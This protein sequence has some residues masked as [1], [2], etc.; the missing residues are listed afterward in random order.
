MASDYADMEEVYSAME[1]LGAKKIRDIQSTDSYAF[2]VK[3]GK[4]NSA[5]EVLQKP[6]FKNGDR[7]EGPY[8]NYT[9]WSRKLLFSAR[10]TIGSSVY[11]GADFKV[12]NTDVV[13]PIIKLKDD[14]SSWKVG[15]E[16]VVSSSDYD[17][18]QAETKKIVKCPTCQPDEVRVEGGFKFMHYGKITFGV[19]ERAEVG[20]LS[21]SVVVEGEVEERCYSRNKVEESLCDKFGEDTYG[22]HILAELG[23]AAHHV[24]QV[25]LFH[26]GQQGILG[27]YPLHFHLMAS[28]PGQSMRNNSAHRSFQRCYTI[29]MTDDTEVSDNVCYDH[30]GHGIFL[31]DSAEQNN[32]IRGNLILGTRHGTT[33]MSD[34]KP[35]WCYPHPPEI[36]DGLASF[37]ITHPNNVFEDNVAAGSDNAGFYFVYADFPVGLAAPVHANPNYPNRIERFQTRYTPVKRFVNNAAHSNERFGVIMGGR[38]S[39]A[40]N[41]EG[42]D[43]PENA[44]LTESNNFLDPRIPN[45]ANGERTS[46]VLEGFADAPVGFAASTS[47]EGTSV[48]VYDSVFIGETRNKGQPFLYTNLSITY[49]A[50]PFPTHFFNR[51]MPKDNPN[52]SHTG[53]SFGEGP[54]ILTNCFFD[55]YRDWYWNDDFQ[56]LWGYRPVRKAGAISFRRNNPEPSMASNGVEGITFGFCDKN[57]H[58]NWVLNREG[59]NEWQMLDGNLQTQFRDHD[60]SVTGL[61][62]TQIVRNAPFFTGE[63][64][65]NHP[66]WGMTACPYRYAKLLFTGDSGVLK[67]AAGAQTYPVTMRRDDAPA[68]PLTLRGDSDIEFLTMTKTSYVVQFNGIVP[69]NFTITGRNME[70]GD[71]I[72]LG[73]CMSKDTDRLRIR[74]EYANINSDDDIEVV[75]SLTDLDNF[76]GSNA[77]YY[78]KRSHMVFF[79]MVSRETRQNVTE[80]CPGGKCVDLSIERLDGADSFRDCSSFT[81]TPFNDN[82]GAGAPLF[83]VTAPQVLQF[84][85]F[86]DGDTDDNDT[87]NGGNSGNGGAK[88]KYKGCFFDRS[89]V[90]DLPNNTVTSDTNT[91]E[92]CLNHCRDAEFEYAGMKAGSVCGCG[93]SYGRYHVRRESACNIPCPGNAGEI[94]GGK[95]YNSIYRIIID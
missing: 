84:T 35:G 58:A 83:D 51:S 60:G 17:W 26:L 40:E 74:S 30:L 39:T 52:L 87:D 67:N 29:H 9:D 75:D 48:K 59:I 80:I 10:S 44:I 42:V 3:K 50:G 2:I 76:P 45:K 93:K 95:Y 37:W 68:S 63:S 11:P 85:C 15:D 53:V 27:S 32:V 92:H 89:D 79:K 94:C 64:C 62:G 65:V 46:Q 13:Y 21:R 69:R 66:N 6:Y 78:D 47:V 41:F 7:V 25:E 91:V 12:L 23:T 24:Q 61:A 49:R 77:V 38:V 82:R 70:R 19:D 71:T 4:T 36:C 16:I 28:S 1:S 34:M 81:F 18:R 55:R 14:V 22:G 72:R 57:N 54:V 73:I 5:Q 20:L 8:V 86:E 90:F 31:E 33:L 43:A 88:G 56:S